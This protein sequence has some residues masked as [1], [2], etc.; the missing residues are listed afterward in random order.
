[1]PFYM[2]SQK[3][4]EFLGI[5]LN[6]S[7]STF[8]TK[9]KNKG[10]TL[11]QLNNELPK[12]ERGFNGTFFRKKSQVQ[13][14]YNVKNNIVYR[15][16]AIID[17][18]DRQSAKSCIMEILSGLD[19]KYGEGF[20]DEYNET[21]LS[22]NKILVDRNFE[23]END[24]NIEWLVIGDVSVYLKYFSDYGVYTVYVDYTDYEN[25]WQNKKGKIDDL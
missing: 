24:G 16:R 5:P 11:H 6:E 7:V 18:N 23:S 14:F 25:F 8:S 4:V 10:F 20:Y 1:M 2:Y 15:A 22:F 12:G 9:L 21:D 17:F 13:L 3:H 19:Y